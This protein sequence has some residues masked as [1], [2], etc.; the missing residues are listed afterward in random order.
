MLS[1]ANKA[2]FLAHFE[3]M[4]ERRLES[5]TA[6]PA[7]AGTR[8][9]FEQLFAAFPDGTATLHEVIA[10]GDWVAF[11]LTQRGTHQGEWM[12]IPATSRQVEWE[13]I[14]T[15]RIVDG[16]IVENHAQPDSIGMLQQLGASPV[17]APVSHG[18]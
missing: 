9:F 11:R 12:G 1:E 4:E 5:L 10:E 8:P 18:A 14:G 13:V 2:V 7:I 6:H 17:A 15:M 3:A 16:M